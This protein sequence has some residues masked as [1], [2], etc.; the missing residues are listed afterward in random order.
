MPRKMTRRQT[1]H[2]GKKSPRATS[3]MDRSTPRRDDGHAQAIE[4]P[5]P[6]SAP[7][8]EPEPTPA[9]QNEPPTEEATRNAASEP[10]PAAREEPSTPDQPPIV[11]FPKMIRRS[12]GSLHTVQNKAEEDQVRQ[13]DQ[14][15]SAPKP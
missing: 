6:T 2:V 4:E 13:S 7:S 10:A 14:Q 15:A 8:S 11:E 3:A 5:T 12:D 1:A 9:P